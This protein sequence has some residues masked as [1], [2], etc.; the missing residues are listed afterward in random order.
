MK[1]GWRVTE[2]ARIA[3]A[4]EDHAHR[5]LAQHLTDSALLR[6][7][8]QGWP[9]EDQLDQA[10]EWTG[11]E[12]QPDAPQV[13]R[14]YRVHRLKVDIEHQF[15]PKYRRVPRIHGQPAGHASWFIDL[16][17][18]FSARHPTVDALIVIDDADGERSTDEDAQRAEAFV[19]DRNASQADPARGLAV[20]FGVAT[21]TAEGWLLDLRGRPN[22]RSA[23]QA[24]C[25]FRA[26]LDLPPEP[27]S[28]PHELIAAAIT[29]THPGRA[30]DQNL[31][32]FWNS[33]LTNVAPAVLR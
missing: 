9:D 24:K 4:G 27:V 28:V 31:R 29:E 13:E 18:L 33:I 3:I 32:R 5:I 30:K 17:N 20:A 6:C 12:N 25:A 14:F 7:Q 26:D 21:P 19:R 1:T 22:E 15:G 10:R 8:R 23:H 2:R 16:Y 11:Y